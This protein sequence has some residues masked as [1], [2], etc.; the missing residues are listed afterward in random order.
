MR[1]AIGKICVSKGNDSYLTC[2][3]YLLFSL[4]WVISAGFDAR[5]RLLG[6]VLRLL[7]VGR[8]G[9]IEDVRGF[10][11]IYFIP[12]LPARLCGRADSLF[13]GQAGGLVYILIL[14]S[15]YTF[16]NSIWLSCSDA[17]KIWYY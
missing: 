11:L 13:A 3:L 5:G 10:H 2:T 6:L 8:K 9:D 17:G 14:F 7:P 1:A 4:S 12:Y 15:I 16:F